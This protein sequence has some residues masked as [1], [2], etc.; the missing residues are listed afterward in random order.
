MVM[1]YPAGTAA[2]L[3]RIS[4]PTL[5]LHGARDILVSLSA[6]RRMGAAHPDWR[7]EVAPDI[8][9]VPMLEAPDWTAARIREW[10]ATD[11]APAALRAGRTATSRRVQLT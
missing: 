10:L 4:Q 3:R 2:K 7:F 9:H 8:G 5:L 1:A 11:G 6:A